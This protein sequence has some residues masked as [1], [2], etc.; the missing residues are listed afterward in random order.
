L[1]KSLK[2]KNGPC[3]AISVDHF[4][5]TS[6]AVLFPAND[7]LAVTELPDCPDVAT[8]PVPIHP[9]MTLVVTIAIPHMMVAVLIPITI[10]DADLDLCQHRGLIRVRR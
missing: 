4:N 10:P 3:R 2:K 5:P 6:I 7:D 8:I 1:G 9:N